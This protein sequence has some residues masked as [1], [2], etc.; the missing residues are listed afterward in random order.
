MESHVMRVSLLH[1][2]WRDCDVPACACPQRLWDKQQEW[3][4][5]DFSVNSVV[6][7]KEFWPGASV[8][9]ALCP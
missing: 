9:L 1:M 4:A 5:R 2:E 7:F 6:H 3:S 8:V